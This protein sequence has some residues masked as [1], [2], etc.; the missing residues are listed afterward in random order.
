LTTVIYEKLPV[1]INPGGLFGKANSEMG[2]G[3]LGVGVAEV[4]IRDDVLIN[5]TCDNLRCD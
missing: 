5:V 4:H 1:E 2:V 3:V